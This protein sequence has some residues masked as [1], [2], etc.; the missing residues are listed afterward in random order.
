MR[1]HVGC[2]HNWSRRKL[3]AKRV[4]GLL[5]LVVLSLAACAPAF[6]CC[7]ASGCRACALRCSS[8]RACIPP[9]SCRIALAS[10]CRGFVLQD[11]GP[12]SRGASPAPAH[13]GTPVGAVATHALACMHPPAR[14]AA[15]PLVLQL[16]NHPF[17]FRGT[18]D[19]LVY[20]ALHRCR[21]RSIFHFFLAVLWTR[22][23]RTML[24][25]HLLLPVLALLQRCFL[26]LRGRL[27]ELLP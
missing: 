21:F 12:A 1:G 25:P 5:A 10:T 15:A 2:T 22:R 19:L 16:Q 27:H 23:S 8:R 26:S 6:A 20:S 11:C 7:F 3:W 4:R 9:H 18:A 24:A 17:A 14:V 13:A